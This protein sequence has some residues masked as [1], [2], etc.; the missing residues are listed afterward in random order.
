M[1]IKNQSPF[2]PISPEPAVDVNWLEARG[3]AALVPEVALSSTCPHGRNVV[4]KNMELMWTMVYELGNALLLW[5]RNFESETVNQDTKQR[6][7]RQIYAQN[8]CVRIHEQFIILKISMLTMTMAMT[9]TILPLNMILA[10]CLYSSAVSK[11][12][13]SMHRSLNDKI[14]F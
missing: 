10:K 12:T 6:M 8:K 2:V 3:L 1:E 5:S 4:C 14:Y 11:D 9:M 13:K 7:I